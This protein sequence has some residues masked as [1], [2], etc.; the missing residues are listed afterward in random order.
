MNSLVI[1]N[2]SFKYSISD[3]YIFRNINID[4]NLNDNKLYK[5]E[6]VNGI[7]K[8]TFLKL[9]AGILK[10]TSGNIFLKGENSL[11]SSFKEKIAYIPTSPNLYP[12]VNAYD[13]IDII[14][15]L[16]SI[17]S[18]NYIQYKKRVINILKKLDLQDLNLD[19]NMYSLGM[20]YKLYFSL[21]FAR[22]PKVLLLDEPLTSLDKNSR[23]IAT[24]LIKNASNKMI[25]IYSS[26]QDEILNEL[27]KKTIDLNKLCKG[28]FQWKLF[29]L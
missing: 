8:T 26:H 3:K 18:I 1:D 5:L 15:E 24:N 12:L 21:M 16:W 10:P 17:K 6:G 11:T 14:S 25:I 4:F 22:N 9:L 7:G 20:V 2:M 28:V 27:Q 13:Y 29:I 19:V 23:V